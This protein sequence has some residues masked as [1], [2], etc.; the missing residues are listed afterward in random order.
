M[1]LQVPDA[2]PDDLAERLYRLAQEGIVNAARHAD[3]SV[4]EVDLTVDHDAI[5]LRI[6]DDGRGFPFRGNVHD[7]GA[8][9]AMNQGPLTLRE[10]VIELH[11]T[12]TLRSQDTGTELLIAVPFA[13]MLR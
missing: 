13:P 10:R 1:Q 7:L 5:R 3:A 12:L 4:I 9:A 6:L 2:L 11:G 8:L